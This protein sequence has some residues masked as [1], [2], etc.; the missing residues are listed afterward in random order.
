MYTEFGKKEDP[1]DKKM[2]E[3]YYGAPTSPNR[4]IN[5]LYT[6]KSTFNLKVQR[7][8]STDL[9]SQS[10]GSLSNK[11]SL[12]YIDNEYYSNPYGSSASYVKT[13]NPH[14]EKRRE[15]MNKST[16]LPQIE[17]FQGKI[18]STDQFNQMVSK[19]MNMIR[20]MK[21]KNK[22]TESKSVHT[23]FKLSNS[24]IGTLS[25]KETYIVK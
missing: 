19:E 6:G 25:S 15:I 18:I 14:D 17:P 4:K 3:F 16:T 10:R 20:D 24:T 12:N 22:R 7:N 1:V 11:L 5:K 9:R 21:K 2:N 13:Y 23:I 8:P